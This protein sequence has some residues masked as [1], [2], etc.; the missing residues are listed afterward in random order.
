MKLTILVNASRSSKACRVWVVMMSCFI[1]AQP[2]ACLLDGIQDAS[3]THHHESLRQVVACRI[4]SDASL[5]FYDSSLDNSNLHVAGLEE[6]QYPAW[7]RYNCKDCGCW[8]SSQRLRGC[9]RAEPDDGGTSWP[10]CDH[11]VCIGQY[12]Q[13]IRRRGLS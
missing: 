3:S 8:P 5:N 7:A 11:S 4:M 1:A 2:T 12:V 6:P 9:F 13:L 10:L